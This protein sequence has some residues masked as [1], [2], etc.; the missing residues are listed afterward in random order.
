M[1]NLNDIDLGAVNIQTDAISF[2]KNAADPKST[3][4][5]EYKKQ[6]SHISFKSKSSKRSG[7]GIPMPP[8]IY[9]QTQKQK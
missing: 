4:T 3:T 9:G 8:S 1:M 2:D 6:K 5:H 7:G